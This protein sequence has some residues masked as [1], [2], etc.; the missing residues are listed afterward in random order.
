MKAMIFAAGLG[1]RLQPLTNDIPKAL[2]KVDDKTLLQHNLERLISFGI[3][4]FVINVHHFADQVKAFFESHN[5]FNVNI[6]VSDE[7]N[8]LLDTGG[9]LKQAAAWLQGDE[10]VLLQN[11][12]IV[13]DINFRK[14]LDFHQKTNAIATL[15]VQHR[16]SSRYLLFN[17]DNR[18]CGWKNIRSGEE[19]ITRPEE[20][21]SSLAFS[22]I[23]M[24]SPEIFRYLP[25][26]NVFGIIEVYLQLSKTRNIAA[27]LHDDDYWFD[28]GTTQKLNELIN[29]M[30]NKA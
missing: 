5:N 16:E 14:M 30:K 8:L 13:T 9:G 3:T 23:H 19:I 27:Y 1:T 7:T 11:V 28:V 15:A 24:V 17:S 4:E 22:G 2:V 20:E 21:Y 6:S 25:R 18:L 12:D 10:P 29:F 26:K